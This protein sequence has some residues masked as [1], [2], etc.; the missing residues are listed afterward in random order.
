[1]SCNQIESRYQKRLCEAKWIFYESNFTNNRVDCSSNE[2]LKNNVCFLNQLKI[3]SFH[4]GDTLEIRI[5]LTKDGKDICIPAPGIAIVRFGFF[6]NS[7]TVT[8]RCFYM[9]TCPRI[10]EID[11]LSE[12]YE[13]M[14]IYRRCKQKPL[15][16]EFILKNKDKIN[17]WLKEEAK[18]RGYIN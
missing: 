18:R 14:G 7:D 10:P 16:R 2:V 8:Y 12:K 6:P 4:I 15:F 17:P 3:D 11:T 5:F 13:S 9:F 1:M